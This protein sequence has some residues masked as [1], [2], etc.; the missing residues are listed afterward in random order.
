MN[1]NEVI[2][3]KAI[4]FAGGAKLNK[5]PILPVEDINKSQSL[6]DVFS[7]SMHI[8]ASMQLRNE[9]IPTLKKLR[10]SFES[11]ALEFKSVI[12]I[13]RTHSM[14][15]FL[16]T[17]GNEFSAFVQQLDNDLQRLEY[18]LEGLYELALG[19]AIIGTDRITIHKDFASK[20]VKHLSKLTK[21][22]FK[23]AKNKFAALSSKDAIVFAHS[24]LKTLATSLLKIANDL[25]ILASGPRCGIGELILPDGDI[26]DPIMPGKNN[27]IHCEILAMVCAQVFGNDT[28]ITFAGAS[29]HLQL[30]VYKPVIIYNFMQSACLLTD[31]IAMFDKLCVRGIKINRTST[32]EHINNTMVSVKALIPQLGDDKVSQI[33][34]KAIK[35]NIS[36]KNAAI[37]LGIL[38]D[39]EYDRLTFP[40]KMLM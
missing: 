38:T 19:G 22:P 9:L 5:T 10:N 28:T 14:D 40:G 24:E 34:N 35:N 6:N 33:A 21:L 16:L 37:T 13:G 7:T 27:P 11:K 30:N 39:D 31:A 36:I 17:F 3:N 8:A 15:S 20:V 23:V 12:K 26:A 4:E 2:A 25:R 18:V 1:A 32:Q 29:G